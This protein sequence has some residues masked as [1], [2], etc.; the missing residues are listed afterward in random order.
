M[1]AKTI[2]SFIIIIL[3]TSFVN[4]Q[5]NTDGFSDITSYSIYE[6]IENPEFGLMAISFTILGTYN[7]L[8]NTL[9]PDITEMKATAQDGAEK[10]NKLMLEIDYLEKKL[11]ATEKKIDIL[12]ERLSKQC[13]NN[14]IDPGETCD[15]GNN[16][17]GD[18]CDENCQLER[19]SNA[20]V[21][22]NEE[23]DDGNLNNNDECKNDCTFNSCGDSVIFKDVE[24]CEKDYDCDYSHFCKNCSCVL[25]PATCG[26]KK[27]ESGEEC[28]FDDTW[29]EKHQ[30]KCN[31]YLLVECD[32]LTCQYAKTNLCSKYCG[33]TSDCDGLQ[34]NVLLNDCRFGAKY[35][36][37]YCDET[38]RM[39][40]DKCKS[41]YPLCT[42]HEA[43]NGKLPGEGNCNYQ[44]KVV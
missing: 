18:G 10:I 1:S 5:N 34:P 29:G 6:R 12:L 42:A 19:C 32:K 36:Q 25:K 22:I 27:I 37:D 35:L 40:D 33:G 44:C 28:E 21:Q 17:N 4:A 24:E 8:K 26:N 11:S 20:L 16:L 15:D 3:L 14:N 31:G 38:C 23:C 9:Y 2:S 7:F 43:C 30:F 39:H 41:G 13:Q